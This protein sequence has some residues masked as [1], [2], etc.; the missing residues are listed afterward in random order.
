MYEKDNVNSFENKKIDEEL[1]GQQKMEQPEQETLESSE[2]EAVNTGFVLVEEP[3]HEA[4]LEASEQEQAA[5]QTEAADEKAQFDID[6]GVFSGHRA[7]EED[8]KAQ[9]FSAKNIEPRQKTKSGLGSKI[10]ALCLS[11]LLFGGCAAGI[12]LGVTY[13]AGAWGQESSQGSELNQGDQKIEIDDVETII[14]NTSIQKENIDGNTVG[15][16]YDVSDVVDNVMPA[17]VSIVNN[18]SQTY[19]TIFGQSYT[20]PAASSGSGIII[21]QNDTEII[22]ASNYHVVADS[23]EIVITFADGQSATAYMKGSNPD[24]DLAVVSVPLDSLSA[25]TKNS[26]AIAKLGNSDSLRLG[27]PVIAIG[28]ALGYGQSVTTGVVSAVD[29]ELAAQEGS[30]G[31][32]IQTDAAINPGNSGG[33]LLNLNGE[34]IGINS[35]KIGGST[36]EGMGYAIP[37]SAA[38]PIISDL[39]LQSTKI[40]VEEGKRG[41]FGVTILEITA[42]EAQKFGMPQGAYIYEFAENSPAEAA[43]MQ[44]RDIVVGLDTFEI[45]S[46]TDLQN[47]LQYY[48]AGTTVAVEVMRFQ[49]NEYQSVMLEVTLGKKASE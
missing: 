25:E 21:G 23:D 7:Q 34:V 1:Q 5:D 22:I 19:N 31:K 27:Q 24:M 15:V 48:E 39:S 14:P 20:Q 4:S 9:P 6:Q 43:G 36:I 8:G 45:S 38:E 32:F 30:T 37:I 44:L 35:N 16:A 29:R 13:A 17:M 26:I 10:A 2:S 18:Y 28:N 49:N 11:G 33:A 3:E 46:F 42:S 12:F 47:A 40:K 41:Y